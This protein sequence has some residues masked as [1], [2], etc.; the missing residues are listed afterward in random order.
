LSIS[1]LP[2]TYELVVSNSSFRLL[3][4]SNYPHETAEKHF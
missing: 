1:G 3:T 4:K 2:L